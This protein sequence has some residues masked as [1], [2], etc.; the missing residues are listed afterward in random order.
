MQQN[1][2]TPITSLIPSPV[3]GQVL[4][5]ALQRGLEKVAC[6]DGAEIGEP[7]VTTEGKKVEV[8]GL[9]VTDE[10]TRHGL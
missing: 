7:V 10:S 8:S 3:S 9:L 2:P 5:D 1:L 4:T 6:L